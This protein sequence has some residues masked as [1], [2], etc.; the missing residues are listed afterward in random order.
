MFILIN[1]LFLLFTQLVQ[2]QNLA[3]NS[4]DTNNGTCSCNLNNGS[5]D[6]S[7][8]CDTDCSTE[9]IKAFNCNQVTTN[10]VTIKYSLTITL[11][12]SSSCVGKQL[13]GLRYLWRETPCPF[14]QA[15]LYSYTDPNLPSPPYIK[16]F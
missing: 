14:K 3:V 11:T 16:Y 8:C 15:A 1:L 9:D 5:C 13:F 7:C 10:E 6:V 2:C 12:I 4:I